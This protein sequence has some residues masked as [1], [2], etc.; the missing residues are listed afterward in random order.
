LIYLCFFA[1]L[2]C[3]SVSS[4]PASPSSGTA[5]TTASADTLPQPGARDYGVLF[6]RN[7]SDGRDEQGRRLLCVQ[8]GFFGAVVDAE[9]A[10]L[11][12]LG[13]LAKARPYTQGV[14]DA[15][16]ASL[17]LPAS[18]SELSVT[19]SG[20]TY[21]NRGG[22]E[23]WEVK[24]LKTAGRGALPVEVGL[25]TQSTPNNKKSNVRLR[26][27]G[28]FRQMFE[29]DRLQFVADDGEVLPATVRLV[30]TAW[31]D[32][33]SFTLEVLPR[34]ELREASAQLQINHATGKEASLS[35][36]AVWAV[37][38]IQRVNVVV[39][40][41]HSRNQGAGAGPAGSV[42]ARDLRTGQPVK[43]GYLETEDAWKVQLNNHANHPQRLNGLDRYALSLTNPT[44]QPLKVRVV[45]A[46]E[47]GYHE[48][49]L[50][51]EKQG[52]ARVESVMGTLLVI[53]DDQGRPTG[54]RIQNSQNWTTW[55]LATKNTPDLQPW[56]AGDPSEYG[57]WIRY[58]TMFELAPRSAW[59][60]EVVVS[61]ALWGGVPQSSYYF[62]SLYGWG[63]YTHWDVAIQG[64]FG[65][66]VCYAVGGYG[67]SDI[68][69]L[70][71]LYMRSYD[72]KRR[73]PFEWTS[74]HGGGNYLHYKTNALKRTLALRREM[75]VPGPNLS[76]TVFH[77]NTSDG[78]IRCTITV[79]QPRTDDLNRSYHR[80]RYEVLAD[81]SFDHL[82]FFQ[83][84]TATYDYY[85]PGA[86]AWGNGGGLQEELPVVP[87]GSADYLRRAVTLDGPAPWWI[88]Q[89]AGKLGGS[90]RGDQP[91]LS[92]STRG[93]IIREWRARLGGQ[94]VA[95]PAL[96]L[97]GS[98]SPAFGVIA[99]ISAPAEVTRLHQGDF[100]EMLV[101]LVLVPVHPEHYLGTNAALK[102]D[103]PALA[104]TWKAVYHQAA[105]NTLRLDLACGTL[106]R[107][108]PPEI[109]V[110]A[111][112]VA[113]FTVTGGSGY[114]P[115]SFTGVTSPA[116]A[117]LREVVGGV[118]VAVDQSDHGQDFWQAEHQPARGSYRITYNLPLDTADGEPVRREF[119]FRSHPVVKASAATETAPTQRPRPSTWRHNKRNR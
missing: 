52:D 6:W 109:E 82:A 104:N 33:L 37:G 30:V 43:V 55:N 78:K 32:L 11:I 71:P 24:D 77:G 9:K 64:S 34:V 105:A 80:L 86:V 81:T 85:Q 76:R 28:Q 7:G 68:T 48:R 40:Y 15:A 73:P 17:Q 46:N 87:T 44:D 25:V 1:L 42:S 26:E 91:Q 51:R 90:Q 84:G 58:T 38:E 49:N 98:Q 74:N 36:V 66:S 23:V 41:P 65:E 107:A 29:I 115:F 101:E 60:G 95:R 54:T 79:E 39:R 110:D 117:D 108:Y 83:L 62:L 21:H 18:N 8:T 10:Q 100:V 99:E 102:R 113:A 31:P 72:S 70:R 20:K 106:V 3:G 53:R 12:Q 4:L 94:D 88:S 103:L 92:T 63:F 56:I 67:P 112:G 119:V 45:L 19:V 69:D 114:V 2:A 96:S 13:A 61:H 5:E 27:Y 59:T 89:H 50:P 35:P 47:M 111:S 22:T 75:P 16:D 93:L 118:E 116:G 14:A 97:L 57:G